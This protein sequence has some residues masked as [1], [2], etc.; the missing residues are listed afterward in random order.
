[1]IDVLHQLLPV[2]RNT[3]YHLRP[4]HHHRLLTH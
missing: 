1:M 2:R 3:R 4:R